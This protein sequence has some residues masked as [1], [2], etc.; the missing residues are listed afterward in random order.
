MK[1]SLCI[2][3]RVATLASA[4]LALSACAD[5]Y[6]TRTAYYPTA[7]AYN[8]CYGTYRPAYCAYPTYSGTVVIGGTTYTGLRYRNGPYGREYWLDG[9]WYVPAIG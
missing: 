4:V 3:V 6:Y 1:K 8:E 7:Y 5:P 9:R 2:A